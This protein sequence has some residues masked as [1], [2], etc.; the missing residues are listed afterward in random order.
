MESGRVEHATLLPVRSKAKKE[1]GDK[2]TLSVAQ[3][4][5]FQGFR[6]A[7]VLAASRRALCISV[8]RVGPKKSYHAA[9]QEERH[10]T[11]SIV[12]SRNDEFMKRNRLT[13]PQ[14][15]TRLITSLAK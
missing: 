4:G 15:D 10:L 11:S 2:D 3:V 6:I 13:K 1:D 12:A 7:N 9:K 8:S 5:D 14:G